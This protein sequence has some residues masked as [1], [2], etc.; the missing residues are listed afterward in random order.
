MDACGK[1]WS[2]ISEHKDSVSNATLTSGTEAGGQRKGTREVF[3]GEAG[4]SWSRTGALR[5]G[6]GV[7]GSGA[8]FQQG[9]ELEKRWRTE[10]RD[11]K[12]EEGMRGNRV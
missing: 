5:R 3:G 2:G 7:G 4:V 10:G 9:E 12:K 1:I 6:A 11:W 8:S